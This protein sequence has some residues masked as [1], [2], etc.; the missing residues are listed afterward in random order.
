MRLPSSNGDKEQSLNKSY[1]NFKRNKT[2]DTFPGV[3]CLWYLDD[4]LYF[5]VAIKSKSSEMYK[6][7]VILLGNTN[8]SIPSIY[9]C[10]NYKPNNKSYD[11]RGVGLCIYNGRY[12]KVSLRTYF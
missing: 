5:C 12:H 6:D 9:I 10:Y 7:F 8:Q 4:N 1:I 2:P 3:G 11:E